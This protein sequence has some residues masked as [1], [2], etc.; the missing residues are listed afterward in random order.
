MS[1]WVSSLPL[2]FAL[3]IKPFVVISRRG[4]YEAQAVDLGNGQ[5]R[6]SWRTAVAGR[7]EL[8]LW[9][10]REK[11]PCSLALD[12]RA[13]AASVRCTELVLPEGSYVLPYKWNMLRVVCKD[14]F[15][16]LTDTEM[17]SFAVECEQREWQIKESSRV[18][19]ELELWIYGGEVGPLSV[20][21][22]LHSEHV[23][24]SP[25]RLECAALHV[26]PSRC[27]GEVLENSVQ[28]GEGAHLLC[29]FALSL[30]SCT[31]R[32]CDR[33]HVGHSDC[34]RV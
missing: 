22:R 25:A 23:C 31:A 6:V 26:D 20:S 9:L 29:L 1:A 24:N 12:V 4:L 18:G 34:H 7:Y 2:L 17:S 5:C 28:S 8:T 14:C 19:S 16:N 15:G 10:W 30:R 33:G 13:G 11:L 3:D 32:S 27:H 21:L